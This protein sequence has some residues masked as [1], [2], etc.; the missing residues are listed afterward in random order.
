MFQKIKVDSREMFYQNS[1]LGILGEDTGV[2]PE[3]GSNY[4]FNK[5]E[6][7]K[8]GDVVSFYEY[9]EIHTKVITKDR[10]K[11]VYGVYGFG[12]NRLNFKWLTKILSYKDL[13]EDILQKLI[14]GKGKENLSI[15][16]IKTVEMTIEEIERELGKKIKIVNK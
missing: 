12:S 11:D 2:K 7:L 5:E 9:G 1:S 10:L 15:V 4:T 16:K 6:T 3:C 13:T 8:V 14:G